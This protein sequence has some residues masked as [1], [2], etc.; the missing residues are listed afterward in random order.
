MHYLRPLL[1]LEYRDSLGPRLGYWAKLKML[2]RLKG[3]GG[4]N[5]KHPLVAADLAFVS[6]W[7]FSDPALYKSIGYIYIY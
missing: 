2:R 5:D 1:R 7:C 4:I 6:Y 3:A